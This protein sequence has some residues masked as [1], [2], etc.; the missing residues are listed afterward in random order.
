MKNEK[1]IAIMKARGIRNSII[2]SKMLEVFL[3]ESTPINANHLHQKIS[4]EIQVD[5]ASVYR[6]LH[7]FKE[8]GILREVLGGSNESYF[9]LATGEFPLH[10]HFWC[11]Q[12]KQVSCL[13]P[14][15]LEETL[16]LSSLA[17]KQKVRSIDLTLKGVCERC[18]LELERGSSI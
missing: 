16:W 12:C 5:L 9:E 14:L 6:N 18:L 4:S 15:S 8:K 10:P 13:S 11:H 7:L 17:K 1:V 2:K 3:E